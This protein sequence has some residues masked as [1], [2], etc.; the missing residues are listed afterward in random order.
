MPLPPDLAMIVIRILGAASVAGLAPCK[1]SGRY[2]GCF[3][4]AANDGRSEIVTTPDPRL[5][6][7]FETVEAAE[8]CW[9]TRSK[10]TP[11]RDDGVPN[12]PLTAYCGELVNLRLAIQTLPDH[13]RQNG[14][15]ALRG[16]IEAWLIRGEMTPMEIATIRGYLRRWMA[17]D[18]WRGPMIDPLRTQ[19]EDITRREDIERWLDRANAVGADPF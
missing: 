2:L 3:D 12:R 4:V 9:R 11:F 18:G 10:T 16:A 5:A 1:E 19:L 13:W 17:W 8:R 15:G 7:R 6:R 14:N